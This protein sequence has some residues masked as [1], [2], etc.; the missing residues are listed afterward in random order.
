MTE[1]QHLDRQPHL[2]GYAHNPSRRLVN[3]VGRVF[4]R[5]TVVSLSQKIGKKTRWL[6]VCSCGTTKSIGASNLTTGNVRSCGCLQRECRQEH[7][8][9]R[10][11]SQ[12]SDTREYKAYMSAQHRCRG[13]RPSDYANYTERGIEFKFTSFQQF[14]DIVGPCSSTKHSLDRIDNDG[15]YEPGNVRWATGGQQNQNRRLSSKSTT[16]FRGVFLIKTTTQ[17]PWQSRVCLNRRQHKLGRFT[18]AEEA[19]RAYDRKA[20]EY[21]GPHAALNFPKI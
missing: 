18:T 6:C 1:A 16:G 15:H 7:N 19:A 2:L 20:L 4:G 13:H 3:L 11:E 12:V 5:L 17:Y 14:L 8:R 9:R 10:L 21:F